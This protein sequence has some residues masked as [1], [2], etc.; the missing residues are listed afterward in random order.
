MAKRFGFF[1]ADCL[2]VTDDNSL[3]LRPRV[4]P[5]TD[6]LNRLYQFVAENKAVLVF[7]TCCS[8]QMLVQGSRNDILFVPLAGQE[9]GWKAQTDQHKL[10]Y[11]QKKAY[12]DPKIN[13]S[14]RAFDVFAHNE[15][16]AALIKELAVDEG[17]VFVNGLDLCVD[18]AVKGIL[19]AGGKVTFLADVMVSSATGYGAFGTPENKAATYENW[20][21]LGATR[22]TFDQFLTDYG[23]MQ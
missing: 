6:K 3:G 16:A 15:N 10:I 22:Q 23:S 18:Q 17:V 1:D 21:S 13:F 19:A 5:L 7:T 12:G 9:Q 20:T 14:C 8:G 11:L 2:E 4:K